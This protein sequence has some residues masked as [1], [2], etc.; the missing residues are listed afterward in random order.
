MTF[1]TLQAVRIVAISGLFLAV[2]L[3]AFDQRFGG[4]PPSQRAGN[5]QPQQTPTPTPASAGQRPGGQ[6]R[7]D[8][9]AWEWWKD[10]AIKKELRLTDRQVR[11]ITRIYENRARD[12]KPISDALQKEVAEREKLARERAVEVAVF[13]IQVN[14]VEALRSELNKTRNV[15]FYAISRMLTPEQHEKLREIFDRRRS[16]RGGGSR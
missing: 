11:D 4:T 15:M 8:S 12:M 6:S 10:E 16:S 9:F 3:L 5:V 7:P 2:P 1:R 13:S 14:R